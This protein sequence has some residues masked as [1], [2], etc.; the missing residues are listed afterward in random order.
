MAGKDPKDRIMDI[1][2]NTLRQGLSRAC[3]RSGVVSAGFHGFRH[4]YARRRL[5]EIMGERWIDGKAMIHYVLK[6]RERGK[7]IDYG[8]PKDEADPDRQSFEWVQDCVNIVH[9]ELGHG[10]SRWA[11]VAVYMS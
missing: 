1:K 5:E 3:K 8:I 7:R 11:L 6:N 10:K 2:E 9:G 4:T